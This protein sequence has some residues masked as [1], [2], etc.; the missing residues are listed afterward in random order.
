[1]KDYKI[2]VGITHGDIN[3]VGYEVILKVLED[4]RI[5]EM[6]TPVVYGSAKIAAFYRKGLDIQNV[7]FNQVTSAADAKD[8]VNN[9]INVVDE[10]TRVEPGVATAEAGMAA[11]AALERAVADL[12]AGDIDVLVTT[13]IIETGLDISNVNTMIIHDADQLGLAQLYQLRGRVGRSNRTAYAFLMYR[14]NKILKE[15]AEKR[16]AAIREF[17]DLGSGFKIAMRDLEIRGAGNIL[18]AEQHGHMEAVGYDLYCKMLNEAVRALQGKELPKEFD[19]VIDMDINAYIPSS[20]IKNEALKLDIYKRIAGLENQAEC[21]DMRKELKDRFGTVPKSVENLIQISL[22]RV[23]AH[24]RYV[25]EIKGK[26]GQITFFMEPYAPVHVE[27]LP[28]LMAKY[29]GVLEFSAKGTP[30]FVL[31]YKKYG[32][33]EKDA[34]MMMVYTGKL[35]TDMAVLYDG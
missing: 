3:G 18:G 22:I 13:T 33:M 21:D 4:T 34:E 9:I 32:L 17:T 31:R 23:M 11:Y 15:V 2:R 8:G 27:R 1:M 29:R 6:C 24:R 10:E 12:R 25:T 20:Y 35:L 7:N 16:L 19:T 5:A 26:T 28:E 14:R 30:N